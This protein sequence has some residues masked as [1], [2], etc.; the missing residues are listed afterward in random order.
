MR[1]LLARSLIPCD[2]IEPV[3]NTIVSSVAEETRTWQQMRDR[4]RL[5]AAYR[6]RLKIDRP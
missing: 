6:Q 2:P 5:E 4:A 3:N 1:K